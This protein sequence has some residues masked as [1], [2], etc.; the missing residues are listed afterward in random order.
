M[1]KVKIKLKD[2]LKERNITQKQ[3]EKMSGVHQARISKLIRE[4]RQE[5]NL[6]MIEKIAAALNITDLS[7]LIGLEEISNTDNEP[8]SN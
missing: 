4:D 7:E 2:V 5:I 6:V 3:L 1:F 8:D